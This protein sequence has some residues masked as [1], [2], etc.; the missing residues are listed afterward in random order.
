MQIKQNVSYKNLVTKARDRIFN[1]ARYSICHSKITKLGW[2]RQ[3]KM[4]AE[5]LKEIFHWTKEN[6]NNFSR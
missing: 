5:S 6:L 3:K 4:N 2:Y 1:D